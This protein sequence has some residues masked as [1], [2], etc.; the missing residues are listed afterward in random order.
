MATVQYS[1]TLVKV[2]K[3]FLKKTLTANFHRDS[4]LKIHTLKAQRVAG[5]ISMEQ[6]TCLRILPITAA[7]WQRTVMSL[8]LCPKPSEQNHSLLVMVTASANPCQPHTFL[9]SSYGAEPNQC[10]RMSTTNHWFQCLRTLPSPSSLQRMGI[11]HVWAV[12]FPSLAV[13]SIAGGSFC[14]Q[15]K[16]RWYF[17]GLP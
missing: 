9:E 15:H 3:G 4:P 12:I 2:G 7:S 10:Q 1:K 5:P 16:T 11:A 6:Y 17:H 14:S 13:N 8:V